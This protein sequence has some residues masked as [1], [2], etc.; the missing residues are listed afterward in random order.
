ML[1]SRSSSTP[2]LQNCALCREELGP[3]VRESRHWL[4]VVNRNQ[5]LLGRCILSLRRHAEAVSELSAEEWADLQD[6]IR[7]STELLAAAFGPDHFN[8][9]FLQNQDRHVHLHVIPR[10][11]G[12]REFG[13]RSFVD[14]DF[15]GPQPMR[16]WATNSLVL[17][18]EELD[19]VARL[20]G[21]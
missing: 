2:E 12:P 11:E 19:A 6:E 17:S 10:Y 14:E 8:F 20:L 21:T 1:C 9:A 16:S 7:A 13:G 5:N 3:V 15:P 18:P 4:L